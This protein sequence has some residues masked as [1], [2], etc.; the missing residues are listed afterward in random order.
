VVQGYVCAQLGAYKLMT[1]ADKEAVF[2]KAGAFVGADEEK[3]VKV[4]SSWPIWKPENELTQRGLGEPGKI[5]D[6]Q[7]AQAYYKTGQWLKSAGRLDNPPSMETIVAH[8][9]TQFAEKALS[10]G[11]K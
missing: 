6:G 2:K 8:I 10:G 3:A 4:G 9:D 11:C 7:V 1:G 5:A